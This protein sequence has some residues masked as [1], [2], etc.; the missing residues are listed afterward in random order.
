MFHL[1]VDRV[2]G[3]DSVIACAY[4]EDSGRVDIKASWNVGSPRNNLPLTTVLYALLFIT[5]FC[6]LLGQ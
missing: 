6:G 4:N 3:S 2:Q 5:L 1:R